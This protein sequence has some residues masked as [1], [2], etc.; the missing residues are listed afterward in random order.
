M[1]AESPDADAA[2]RNAPGALRVRSIFLSDIHLGTRACQAGHLLEFLR[3][4]ETER[5]YLLGDIVDFW[6]LSREIH[7][8]ELH[9]TFVQKILKRARHGVH[10]TF[11][12]G[13]HD[14]SLREYAGSAFGDIQVVREAV[15]V[16]A[17]GRRYLLI[18]GDEF[19]QITRYHRWLA[20]LG[21]LSYTA[22]VRVNIL[23]SWARRKL[24]IPGYWSLAGYAKRKVKGALD[25]IYGFEASVAHH[26]GQRGMD[27]VICGHIHSAVVKDIGGVRYVNCGDWVDSCSAVLEHMDGRIELVHWEQSAPGQPHERD[28][29]AQGGALG[30]AF[31]QREPGGRE[32][33]DRGAVLEPS[34]LLAA[35][36]ACVAIDPVGTAVAKVQQHIGK[37]QPDAGDEDRGHR[38]QR[39]HVV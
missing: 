26:A 9:N 23:L 17:D 20:E 19:D 6:A 35:G 3:L 18:H 28:A 10:V 37:M 13:N 22:L 5:I 2:E 38:H 33:D 16:G 12:P 21:D 39:H 7:W 27:G 24:G 32:H 11:V 31:A 4:H 29:H 34:H 30:H 8:P 36:K 15:H 1:S 14:E 25:F